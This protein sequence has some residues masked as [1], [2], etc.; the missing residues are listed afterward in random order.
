MFNLQP[1]FIRE[2]VIKTMRQFFYMQQFHEVIP[3]NLNNAIPLEPNI[4]TFST[5]WNTRTAAKKLFLGTSP[6]RNMKNMLAKGMGNCFAIGKCFRNLEGSG[7]K[8]IPEFLMLEWY[9]E[10]E[11]YFAL[12]SDIQSMILALKK[13]IDTYLQREHT[14]NL[15]YGDMTI[16][17]SGEWPLFSTVELWK[18]Y[19]GLD[20]EEILDEETLLKKA[21]EKGYT[22]DGATWSQLYDQ[23]FVNEIEPHLPLTPF[24]VNDFPAR[25]SP[26]CKVNKEKPYLAERFEFYMFGMELA[27]GNNENLDYVSLKN[28]FEKES[29]ARKKQGIDQPVDEDFLHSLQTMAES[30][31]TYTGIGMGIDRL[32]MIFA[33]KEHITDVEVLFP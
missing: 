12:M 13:N 1:T 33:N 4:Y 31:K 26:L 6:E 29:A 23:I 9:R 11:D 8:H 2:E 24:F 28:I 20:L 32:A 18:K 16:D 7:S 3:M 5:E 10:N 15:T 25:L 30:G 27:N 19:A 22:T 17:L 14:T 21:P